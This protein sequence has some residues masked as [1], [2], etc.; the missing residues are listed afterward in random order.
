MVT[1]YSGSVNISKFTKLFDSSNMLQ[2]YLHKDT[3]LPIRK[4]CI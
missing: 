4:G 1:L 2:N 3:T